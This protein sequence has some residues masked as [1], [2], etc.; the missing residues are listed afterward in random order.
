MNKYA[1]VFAAAALAIAT[2]ASMVSA[3]T[4]QVAAPTTS[5]KFCDSSDSVTD[6]SATRSGN[7][8][9]YTLNNR[10]SPTFP[11][12]STSLINADGV[13][14]TSP[15]GQTGRCS[16]AVDGLRDGVAASKTCTTAAFGTPG[17][18]AFVRAFVSGT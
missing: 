4:C 11:T 5:V 12:A 18:P 17:A 3:K 16:P 7:L 8:W 10:V 1:S 14:F 13:T 2:Q 15:A 9:T 6:Y